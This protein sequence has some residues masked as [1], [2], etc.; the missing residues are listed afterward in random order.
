MDKE[1]EGRGAHAPPH[2]PF[3]GVWTHR[4]QR[5]PRRVDTPPT[6]RRERGAP[7]VGGVS[8][9]RDVGGTSTSRDVGG[10]STSRGKEELSVPHFSRIF[11]LTR[12]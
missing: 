4:P 1:E 7:I 12:A 2:N 11:T 3:R 10:M 5:V 9:P 8:T 6:V